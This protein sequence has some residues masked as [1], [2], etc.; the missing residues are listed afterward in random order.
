MVKTSL[1]GDARLK[2]GREAG[3][4]GVARSG[5]GVVGED[6]VHDVVALAPELCGLELRELLGQILGHPGVEPELEILLDRGFELRSLG[7]VLALENAELIDGRADVRRHDAAVGVL[8]LVELEDVLEVVCVKL[9][10]AV[11]GYD[12]LDGGDDLA[13]LRLLSL[14][15][16]AAG[17]QAERQ[18]QAE[19]GGEKS[20][21]FGLYCHSNHL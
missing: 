14:R 16:A 21:F 17:Q 9:R 11:G 20:G 10:H 2:S 13:H 12:G 18:R 4:K 1:R 19:D 3:G 5:L 8:A 6:S 15:G 7:A